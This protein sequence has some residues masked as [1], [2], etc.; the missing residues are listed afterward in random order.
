MQLPMDGNSLEARLQVDD[1]GQGVAGR[2]QGGQ[3]WARGA[4]TE[5]PSVS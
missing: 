3:G 5:H 4:A 1:G 2:G